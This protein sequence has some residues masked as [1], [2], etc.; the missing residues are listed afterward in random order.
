MYKSKAQVWSPSFTPTFGINICCVQHCKW[1]STLIE[2]AEEEHPWLS[3]RHTAGQTAASLSNRYLI[4]G[5]S[6]TRH[7]LH[8]T[9]RLVDWALRRASTG[10]GMS[11]SCRDA[12]WMRRGRGGRRRRLKKRRFRLPVCPTIRFHLNLV[13]EWQRKRKKYWW[14][15]ANWQN[16][17]LSQT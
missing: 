4:R 13:P 7:L 8:P 2:R 14:I 10:T 5:P 6:D 9:A 16:V 11:W 1:S 12:D 15:T 3:C 17:L